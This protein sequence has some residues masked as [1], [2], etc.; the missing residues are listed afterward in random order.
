M[1]GLPHRGDASGKGDESSPLV[2]GTDAPDFHVVGLISAYKEGRLVDGAIR[3]LERVRANQLY[4]FEGPAGEPLG[5]D[6]PDSDYERIGYLGHSDCWI[7][8]DFPGGV[9]FGR[10][11]TDARKR[12]AMLEEAK[13][14]F[15]GPLWGVILDGDEILVNGEYLRDIIQSI[16]WAD[17]AR[18]ASVANPDEPPTMGL[19]LWLVEADG[20]MAHLPNRVVR[21][22]LIRR[23]VVSTSLI[24]NVYGIQEGHANE[25]A[26]SLAY[27]EAAL[28]A[29][30]LMAW[31][32]FPCEPHIFHR[33]HLRHP[34]R[35]GA[36]MHKQE[37][38][39]FAKLREER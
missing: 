25:A 12:T 3:S 27:I 29:G 10:W 2:A 1:S 7:D 28:S 39:E 34:A 9:Y 32:P 19:P 4:I 14:R 35:R 36:R 6:V 5:D 38:E 13:R 16:M 18:G 24:E 20:A 17:E 33:S 26:S 37:A 21:L 15:P 22:D 8:E 23:Y 31:P 30:R 11:R